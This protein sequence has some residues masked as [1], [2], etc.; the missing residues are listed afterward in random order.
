MITSKADLKYYLLAD[1]I[2]L[3]VKESSKLK[4]LIFPN[5]IWRFQR[6]LRYLEYYTNCKTWVGAKITRLFL[7]LSYRRQSIKLGFSIPINC[8]GPGL[9]IAHIGPIIINKGAHIGS[10]CLIHVGVNIGTAAGYSDEAPTIGNNCYIGPGVKIF[11]NIR[12]ANNT[13]IGANAVV[14]KSFLQENTMIAGVPARVIKGNVDTFNY[15]RPAIKII[16]LGLRT[17]LGGYPALK[18]KEILREDPRI[19]LK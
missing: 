10:N 8:I 18:V 5:T 11:G 2:A 14:N 17:D 4:E 13:A 6:T 19:Y 9:A 3:S 16:E 7:F 15:V 12:I 1:K